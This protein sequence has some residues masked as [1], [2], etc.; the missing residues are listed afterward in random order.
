MTDENMDIEKHITDRFNVQQV[1]G[2]GVCQ[3]NISSLIDILISQAYGIVWKCEDKENGNQV[4]A[5]KKIFSAFQNATDAQRTFRE[6]IFLQ[7][8]SDHDNIVTLLD[9]INAHNDK[10]IYLVFEFMGMSGAS[11]FKLI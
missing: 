9:V 2:K 10:D 6:I 3:K 5:L 11:R 4:V 8:L 1:L 7:A